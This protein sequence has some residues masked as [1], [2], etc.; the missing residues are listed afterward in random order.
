MNAFHKVT[1]LLIC[2]GNFYELQEELLST[3]L[4]SYNTCVQYLYIYTFIFIPHTYNIC[5]YIC[6]VNSCPA[7]SYAV[8][9]PYHLAGEL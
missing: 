9:L 6:C 8:Y 7:T 5:V 3:L 4:Q 1:G 2:L